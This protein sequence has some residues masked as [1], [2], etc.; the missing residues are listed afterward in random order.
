MFEMPSLVELLRIGFMAPLDLP[1][2]LRATWRYVPVRDAQVRKVPGEL[3][4]ERSPTNQL[5]TINGRFPKMRLW[6]EELCG[7]SLFFSGCPEFPTRET[8]LREPILIGF[9]TSIPQHPR[10]LLALRKPIR[11][12]SN[13]A[14]L[15]YLLIIEMR[16]SSAQSMLVPDIGGIVGRRSP[17]LHKSSHAGKVP[18]NVS[19]SPREL[20]SRFLQ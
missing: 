17:Y 4:S 16:D 13:A 5:R 6:K 18:G 3:W 14:D 9:V 1:V 19:N 10:N 11:G 2:H 7:I 12:C 8:S 20:K 15:A